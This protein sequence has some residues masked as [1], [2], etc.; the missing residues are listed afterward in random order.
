MKK[1]DLKRQYFIAVLPPRDAV[2]QI[3]KLKTKGDSSWGW[4]NPADYHISLA[5]PGPLSDKELG[6]LKKVLSGVKHSSFTM[7]LDELSFFLR[8]PLNKKSGKHIL[9]ARANGQA[10]NEIKSLHHKII[11][12][13]ARHGFKYGKRDMTPHLT[14]ARVEKQDRKL[15]EDFVRA[16]AK[17]GAKDWHCDHFVLCE[18]NGPDHL[19]DSSQQDPNKSR[20]KPVA[21]FKFDT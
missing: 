5:F 16:N 6:R 21:V 4:N 12:R 13:M 19:Q 15:M 1:G 20:Y 8:S 7:S 11:N 14:V 3:K 10:D 2:E 18:S 17:L 9:W